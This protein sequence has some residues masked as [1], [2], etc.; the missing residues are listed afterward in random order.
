MSDGTTG[1]NG[2]ASSTRWP[3]IIGIAVITAGLVAALI[4]VNADS[5]DNATVATSDGTSTPSSATPTEPPVAPST[6]ATA[7][8]TDA[9][10]TAPP[11]SEPTG[12]VPSSETRDAIWPLADTSTRFADPVA[13]VTSFAV[14]YLGFT[15]PIIGEFQEGDARSGEIEVRALDAGPSTTVLVR[16][17]TDD[18]TWWVLGAAA[19]N[20]MIDEPTQGSVLTDP[21]TLSGSASAFEG[22]V[23]VELRTDTDGELIYEG[24]VTGSGT[25]EPGPYST[26]IA[27]ESP[28]KVGGAL[29]MLSRSSDDGRVIEASAL[30]VFF[31]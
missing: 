25:P 15:D 17:L 18:D 4:F 2:V 27:F 8:A 26:T 6:D 29:V 24:F 13:A 14:D 10:A 20:I 30:R 21:F 23:N 1:T 3:L 11:G 7:P 19:E 22:T 28:G 16:R 31:E 12:T 5:D 9:P